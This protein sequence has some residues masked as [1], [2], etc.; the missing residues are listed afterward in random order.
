MGQNPFYSPT[1]FNYY[2]PN[3]TVPGTALLAPE[4]GILNTSTAVN[5]INSAS[6]MAFVNLEPD[7]RTPPDAPLGTGTDI[8]EYTE[9][10]EIDPTGNRLLD[11]LNNR[12]MHGT[13]SPAMRQNISDAILLISA[14]DAEFRAKTAIFLVLSSMDYQIQR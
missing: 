2:S 13:M 8:S 3:Y 5:R 12:F 10:S 14:N 6:L 4:F 1:V 9:F 11:E 7:T